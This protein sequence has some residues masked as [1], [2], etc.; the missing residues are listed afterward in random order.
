MKVVILCGGRGTRLREETEFR[1]K[2]MV[3][4]GNRPILWHIMKIYAHFGHREFILCLGYKADMIREYFRN[5]LWNTCDTTLQLG[6]ERKV[7]FHTRHHEEDWSV[8]LANT[9]EESLTG[10]RVKAIQNYIPPNEPF[11]LT[12]G[13]GVADIDVNESIRRHEK[14]GKICTITAVHPAGRFGALMID[15]DDHI[16]TFMEKPRIEDAYI[17]GGFMVCD[18]RMFDYVTDDVGMM[19]E[20]KP[21]ADLVRD[22]E[23]NAYKHEGFWQA[24]DTYQERL[25]L[26]RMWQ[27]GRAPWRLWADETCEPT[28][29]G[30][31]K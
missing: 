24:M 11:L 17:N 19:L 3:P 22:G 13:D 26:E 8:T 30:P 7:H 31:A 20:Q 10:Y 5:Y 23:L 2:P 25:L 4:I 14:A 29:G 27:E 15:A 1:P 16:H 28:S 12:Y 9:G 21:M 18:H 6:R